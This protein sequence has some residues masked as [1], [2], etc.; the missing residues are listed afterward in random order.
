MNRLLVA[1]LALLT[2]NLIYGINYTV[3]KN[4][5]PNYIQPFGFIFCR[6]SGALLLFWLVHSLF[7]KEK[8][9]KKDVPRI[10][11]CGLFGVAINQLLFFKG[12]NITTPINAAIIMTTNPILVLIM[13]SFILKERITRN[14]VMGIFFGIVGALSLL[15]FGNNFSFGSTTAAGDFMIFINAASYGIYL[16]LVKPLMG[17]YKPITVIKWVFFFGYLVVFPFG[18]NEFR[19]I[20]WADMPFNIVLETLFVIIGTTFLA[21][22]LNIFALKN[23]TPSAASTYI[24]LQPAFAGAIAIYFG[25]DDLNAIKIVA[26]ILIFLGVYLVSKPKKAS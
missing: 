20:N 22:L 11:L 16:V 1:H 25:K 23:V 26:C 18:W 12:L 6:V 24:Y 14:K 10:M 13:A 7:F 21:Y 9:E 2:T 19:E 8:I 5:M 3:A 15:L 17:K 4:V